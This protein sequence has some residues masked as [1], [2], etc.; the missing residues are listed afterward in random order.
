MKAFK[1]SRRFSRLAFSFL[2]A[3]A[4]ISLTAVAEETSGPVSKNDKF[5]YDHSSRQALEEYEG[6]T[7]VGPVVSGSVDYEALPSKA[8]KFLQKHCDG[9][10]VVKCQREFSSGE[11]DIQL[12]DGIEF[13][14]DNKGNVIDTEAPE[15]YSLSSP[16]LKAIVPGKLYQLLKHNGFDQSVEAVHHDRSGYR[17]E[18]S[19]P[20]FKA[21]SYDPSGV[22]TLVV[23]E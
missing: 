4:G 23:N 10:A 6:F 11:F 9:H 12:A 3:L 15:G 22:L 16:L 17:I 21:V 2:L 20:V 1:I 7:G 13:E 14:F 5:S 19:D 18:V 8:R